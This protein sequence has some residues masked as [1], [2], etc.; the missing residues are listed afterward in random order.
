MDKV[1]IFD[2]SE[3]HSASN[4]SVEVSS[5]DTCSRI[6][7]LQIDRWVRARGLVT[8]PARIQIKEYLSNDPPRETEFTKADGLKRPIVS[9]CQI[10]TD[11]YGKWRTDQVRA[12][13]NGCNVCRRKRHMEGE[14]LSTGATDQERV[15]KGPLR[16]PLNAQRI[17]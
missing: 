13:G 3:V 1:K 15:T 10:G 16:K 12:G 9:T 11:L 5:V 6:F 14:E 4:F 17:H 7:F 8:G 2:V